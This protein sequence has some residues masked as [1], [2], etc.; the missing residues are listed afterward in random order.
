MMFTIESARKLLRNAGLF[1]LDDESELGD[2]EDPKWLQTINFNDAWSWGSAD[3]E[4]VEDSE[5]PEVAE[6]FWR[7]GWCGVLYWADEKNGRHGAEFHDVNRFIQ[8]VREEEKVRAEIPSSSSRAYAKRGY[9]IGIAAEQESALQS[10]VD[11][12]QELGMGYEITAD[13]AD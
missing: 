4:Y 3:C 7:Y 11:E 2:G 5:L 12:A 10:L 8:F 13:G 1:Y 6:L 9:H